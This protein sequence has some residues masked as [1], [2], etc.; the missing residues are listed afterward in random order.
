VIGRLIAALTGRRRRWEA[1]CRQCGA[2]CYR[3]EWRDGAWVVNRGSP[4]GFLDTATRR[5]TVYEHRFTACPDCKRMTLYH[6]MF[7]PWLPDECGY[8]QAYR[9][10]RAP[11][12]QRNRTAAGM[13][14]RV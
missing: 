6:A 10:A 12:R 9:R 3:K 1:L 14:P 8:V 7:T 5:C 13:P 4:C 11:D 2:C